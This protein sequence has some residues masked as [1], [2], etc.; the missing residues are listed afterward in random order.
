MTIYSMAVL[1][2][3]MAHEGE[4]RSGRRGWCDA[5]YRHAERWEEPCSPLDPMEVGRKPGNDMGIY[6][7][8]DMGIYMEI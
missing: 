8:I 2:P 7:G 1:T 4:K 5:G 6:M 3:T